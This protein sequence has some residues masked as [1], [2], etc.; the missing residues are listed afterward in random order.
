MTQASR[1]VTDPGRR[2]KQAR[3]RRTRQQFIMAMQKLLE[4]EE[5]ASITVEQI[6]D[7]AHSTA[8]NF[9]KHFAGKRELLSAIVDELNST[10]EMEQGVISLPRLNGFTLAKRVGW[11]V[12]AVA[13]ATLRRRRLA[14]ACIA[15]RYRADLVLSTSQATRLR[16]TMKTI[17]DWLLECSDEMDR[18]DP[19][20]SVRAS[21]YLVLQGLQNALL[22]EEL[23]PDLPESVLIDE[24]KQSLL[25]C[26][27]AGGS[28]DSQLTV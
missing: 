16:A 15:A 24:A 3:S 13:D 7:T 18:V 27:V 17:V 25:R 11:L 28:V 4:K 21:T 12:D 6:S 14:R 5:Y 23:P 8:A 10:A 20:T 19:R 2:A 22:F 26:W 9:Y 1:H